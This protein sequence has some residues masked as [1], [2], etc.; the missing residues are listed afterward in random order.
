MPTPADANRQLPSSMVNAAFGEVNVRRRGDR[1]EVT[2]TVQMEPQGADAEGWQTG[3]A[4]D[5][6]ASMRAAFGR[7]LLGEVPTALMGDYRKKGWLRE[8]VEDGRSVFKMR[9]EA[10]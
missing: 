10:T 4:L 1:Q 9:K 7:S 3:V 5:A 6:S 2:F 8:V